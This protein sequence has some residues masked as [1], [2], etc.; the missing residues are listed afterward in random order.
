M[1]K[2]IKD[3]FFKKEE[4]KVS[5][6]TKTELDNAVF[7]AVPENYSPVKASAPE[8]PVVVATSEPPVVITTTEVPALATEQLSAIPS[9]IVHTTTITAV[10]QTAVVNAAEGSATQPV[11]EKKA[12]KPRKPKSVEFEIKPSAAWPFPSEKPLAAITQSELEALKVVPPAPKKPRK[13]TVV[14]KQG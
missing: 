6:E 4:V 1:F 10:D 2:K 3:W 14:P 7:K 8:V 5:A 9:P 11:P 12:R 13:S